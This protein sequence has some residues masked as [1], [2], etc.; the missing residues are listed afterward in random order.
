MPHADTSFIPDTIKTKEDFW[1]HVYT[2]IQSLI[3]VRK[4]WVS[5]RFLYPLL[6]CRCGCVR[7]QLSAQLTHYR[8]NE[9]VKRIIRHLLLLARIPGP[10]W[11]R[12]ADGKLVW[13]I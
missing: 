3:R 7:S 11:R 12:G 6:R 8:G 2:Q 13:Y 10:F 4:Q 9:P 5:P 1:A